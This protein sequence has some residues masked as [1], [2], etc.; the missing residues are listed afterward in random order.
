MAE[1]YVTKEQFEEFVKRMEQAFAHVHQRLD[2]QQQTLK[3][4]LDSMENR[5][6]QGFAGIHADI[7]QLR[8]WWVQLF[9][10]VIFGLVFFGFIGGMTLMLFKELI[11]R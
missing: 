8:N 10:L 11:F 1:G 5:V 9:G 2:D 4:H 6:E 7:R 3:Q